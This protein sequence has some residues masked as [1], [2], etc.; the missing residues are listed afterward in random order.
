MKTATSDLSPAEVHEA[1]I[2]ITTVSYGKQYALDL[3]DPSN[4]TVTST[5]RATSIEIDEHS[6]H[7]RYWGAPSPS[8]GKCKAMG[9]AVI[10][11]AANT[12][13]TGTKNLRVEYDVRC[14][15]VVDLVTLEIVPVVLN[16]TML[17]SHLYSFNLVENIFKLVI[18]LPSQKK[19]DSLVN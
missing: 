1:I 6:S 18:H 8:D 4:T 9:R 10:T 5:T 11:P 16:M 15:P 7:G 13:R 12:V 19:M 14:Q 2:E 3:Y 17:I